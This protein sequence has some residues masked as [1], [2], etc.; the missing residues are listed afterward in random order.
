MEQIPTFSQLKAEPVVV[1]HGN[2]LGP[3]LILTHD[4]H[5]D[6]AF[7]HATGM[8]PM[9]DPTPRESGW[10]CWI[11]DD[12]HAN[13]RYGGE[14]LVTGIHFERTW[15]RRFAERALCHVLYLPAVGP[16][17]GIDRAVEQS[18]AIATQA[19]WWAPAPLIPAPLPA[20]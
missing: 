3:C 12:G 13:L 14:D 6:N 4:G 19:G 17:A 9:A 10:E 5:R 20:R 18:L 2:G 7:P 8:V 11:G 15:L 1:G 16:G